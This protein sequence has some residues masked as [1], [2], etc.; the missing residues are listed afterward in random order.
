MKLLK[1]DLHIS[2]KKTVTYK[3]FKILKKLKSLKLQNSDIWINEALFGF[4]QIKDYCDNLKPEGNLLEIGSGTDLYGMDYTKAAVRALKDAISHSSITLF[5]SLGIDHNEMEVKI[6]IG[7]QEPR[8][9][10]L[11]SLLTQIPG[12]NPVSYKSSWNR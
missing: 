7:V 2:L 10:N 4:S 3:N 9:V 1:I 8:K 6:T 12:G 11:N 5:S